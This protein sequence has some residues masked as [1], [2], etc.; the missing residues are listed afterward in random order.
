MIEKIILEMDLLQNNA[1]RKKYL[2]TILKTYDSDHLKSLCASTMLEGD[3]LRI[4]YKTS[5]F[6]DFKNKILKFLKR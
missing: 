2:E 1:E 4:Y 3:F 6:G 5:L